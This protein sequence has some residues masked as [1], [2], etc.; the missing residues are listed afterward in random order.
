MEKRILFLSILAIGFSA[1]AWASEGTPKPKSGE[2]PDLLDGLVE[3]AK[4]NSMRVYSICEINHSVSR[5]VLI[6]PA[7]RC[8]NSYSVTKLFA[9]TAVG[10]LEDRGKLDTEEF[11]Y[12]IFRDRFP[13]G[14]DPKWEQVKISD[15]LTHR[16]GIDQGFLDIDVENMRSWETDDFLGLVLGHS[17]KYRPG[18]KSVYSDAAFY[19]VSR[20]VTEKSGE[21]LDDFLLREVLNPLR[22]AEFAFSQCPLGYPIGATGLY[23]STEDMAKLGQLYVQKGVYDGKRILSERFVE[24]VFERGFELHPVGT[25]GNAYAKGGMFGQL[26]YLNRKTGRVIAIHSFDADIPKLMEY[27]D[28]FDR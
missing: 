16:I 17:L 9:V 4:T 5:T 13:A 1:I 2:S 28:Q 22:F 3:L 21:R 10:I 14:Y 25:S 20:I 8:H 24:K 18:E 7:T 26:L 23:I 19:L 12:P 6:E 11:V 27:L 15:V